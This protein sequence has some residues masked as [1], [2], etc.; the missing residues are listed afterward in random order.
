MEKSN[1]NKPRTLIALVDKPRVYRGYI[2]GFRQS[3]GCLSLQVQSFRL[4]D[5][6]SLQQSLEEY[7]GRYC[8]HPKTIRS[9][10]DLLACFGEAAVKLQQSARL[11]VFD[12]I[13]IEVLSEQDGAFKLW[14]PYFE[15]ECFHLAVSFMLQFF[16]HHLA[17]PS[18]SYREEISEE[19]ALLIENLNSF[20]PK[21]MNSLRILET[22]HQQGG[23][24]RYLT[25][26]AFQ[27]GYGAHSRWFDS[28]LTD[29]TPQIA[30]SIARNKFSTA[31]FLRKMGIPVPRHEVVQSQEEAVEMARQLGYP[32]VIKPNHQ[33]GGR[34]VSAGLM[35]DEQVKKAFAKARHY[36]EIVLL[37][38]HIVGKDYRL[39]V[40]NGTLVWAIERVPAGVTGDGKK[41]VRELIDQINRSRLP[42]GDRVPTLKPIAV[43]EDTHEVLSHQGYSLRSVPTAGRFVQL[44]RISNIGSGG[45]PVAVFDE[46]HPDNKRLAESA[47][48][49]L[50]LDIAGIDLIMPDIRQSYLETGGAVIEINAQPQIGTVTAAHMY[51]LLLKMFVPNQGRIP[52]IVVCSN[53]A[54]E[55][56]IDKLQSSLSCRYQKIGWASNSGGYINQQKVHAAS[57]SYQ[58]AQAL[59]SDQTVDLI[60]YSIQQMDDIMHEGLPFDQFDGLLFLGMPRSVNA[61]RFNELCDLLHTL[62]STCRGDFLVSDPS[63]YDFIDSDAPFAPARLLTRGEI[64]DRIED[65]AF[66]PDGDLK[67]ILSKEPVGH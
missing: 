48:A 59:L 36:S 30:A 60:I 27:L 16:L 10:K 14:I 40:F 55:V 32:V 58:A 44:S 37:E 63:V 38:Q 46:V 47:A 41:S 43:D 31:K 45:V 28:T 33:D 12:T 29:K 34:G 9:P 57:S 11:P 35:T 53:A 15:E 17:A 56:I 25:Q 42:E 49:L 6:H 13:R 64:E 22:A 18:F 3:V 50:R 39:L 61:P 4:S 54:E 52:V 51:P 8:F 67:R 23:S 2:K 7:G 1:D 19:L 26:N 65:G 24:W 5:V 21:G 20:A 62:F 66:L